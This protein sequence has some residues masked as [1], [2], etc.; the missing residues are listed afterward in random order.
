MLNTVD[1]VEKTRNRS[2]D[3]HWAPGDPPVAGE[4]TPEGPQCRKNEE[5]LVEVRRTVSRGGRRASAVY[6]IPSGS[7]TRR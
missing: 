4:G 5:P 6:F 7:E 1:V 2:G 3:Q